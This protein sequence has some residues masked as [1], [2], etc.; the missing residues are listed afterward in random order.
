MHT[1][2]RTP[3]DTTVLTPAPG[4]TIAD[5]IAAVTHA[6]D[7]TAPLTFQQ[8]LGDD[9]VYTRPIPGQGPA[10][11]VLP[12]I[13]TGQPAELLAVARQRRTADV[14]GQCPACR[15]CLDLAAG[16]IAHDRRCPVSDDKL[17]PALTRWARQVGP[18]R[19]RR[20]VETPGEQP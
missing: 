13:W 15:A 7:Q 9:D 1:R 11:F 20:I 19:G 16:Q 10:L 17:R 4:A 8:H 5:T 3:K 2:Q 18:A 6:V 14:T 12:G